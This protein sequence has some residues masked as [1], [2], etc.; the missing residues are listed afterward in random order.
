[1]KEIITEPE[2]VAD[3]VAEKVIEV[4]GKPKPVQKIRN[5]QFATA[6]LGAS[7]LALFLVGVEKVFPVHSPSI[8]KI[9][10]VKSSK[11]RR[12]KLYYL[13]TAKGAK[14]K[15][16][17]KDLAVAIAPEEQPVLE[18]PIQAT[19]NPNLQETVTEKSE[20]TK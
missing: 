16:K 20:E 10:V 8:S 5:S 6:I 4:L 1:M 12:S 2:K 18:T 19:E 17:N 13:R 7:G 9:E 15:L 11:V 14:G 3:Q